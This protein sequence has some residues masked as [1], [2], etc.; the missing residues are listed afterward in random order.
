MEAH[1]EENHFKN[2]TT[3]EVPNLT[4]A[5]IYL[6]ITPEQSREKHSVTEQVLACKNF[7]EKQGWVF[8][9]E[10]FVKKNGM[11]YIDALVRARAWSHFDYLVSFIT[12]S[13]PDIRVISWWDAKQYALSQE[14]L[15]LP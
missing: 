1:K 4:L 9:G 8:S 7:I 3:V 15:Q 5:A 2:Q 12:L 14:S 10:I 13:D 11:I 6:T